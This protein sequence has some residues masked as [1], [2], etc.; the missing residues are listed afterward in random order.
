MLRLVPGTEK[1]LSF[2]PTK[3]YI[4]NIQFPCLVFLSFPRLPPVPSPNPQVCHLRMQKSQQKQRLGALQTLFFLLSAAGISALF[5][6]SSPCSWGTWHCCWSALQSLCVGFCNNLIGDYLMY[7]AMV[8]NILMLALLLP[9]S[10]WK[11]REIIKNYLLH[12]KHLV[13]HSATTAAPCGVVRPCLQPSPHKAAIFLLMFGVAVLEVKEIQ[14]LHM[15]EWG[16]S[17][18][19]HRPNPKSL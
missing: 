2:S 8:H 5:A 10:C 12:E 11:Q 3:C 6:L 18:S 17:H 15:S 1:D 13:L 16:K 19:F 14:E 9:S 7:W 4:S